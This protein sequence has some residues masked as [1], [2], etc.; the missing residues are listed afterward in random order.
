MPLDI[1][2]LLAEFVGLSAEERGIY[3]SLI[4]TNWRQN[5]LTND[6]KELAKLCGLS[7][8]RFK[9]VAGPILDRLSE[10]EGGKLFFDWVEELRAEQ[11]KKAEK[12]HKRAKDAAKARWSDDAKSNASSNAKSTPQAML[13]QCHSEPEPDIYNNLG[14]QSESQKGDP[15][16][17][18][19]P[20]KRHRNPPAEAHKLKEYQIEV[21]NKCTGRVGETDH[22]SAGMFYRI[23]EEVP[24]QVVH[25]ALG[26]MQDE[27]QRNLGDNPKVRDLFRYYLGV[28]RSMCAEQ[29]IETSINWSGKPDT[30]YEA[31]GNRPGKTNSAIKAQTGVDPDDLSDLLDQPPE[32]LP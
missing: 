1:D 5:G 3:F 23:G 7:T 21:I 32:E 4:A 9:R 8:R 30:D 22:P 2:R 11:E 10:A 14:K 12:Y 27:R 26:K 28:L 24:R 17:E 16:P 29:G 20:A 15:A 19:R 13:E 18:P 31:A 6:T 25:A